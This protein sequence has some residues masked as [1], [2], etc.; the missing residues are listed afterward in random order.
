MHPIDFDTAQ[1]DFRAAG[2]R[3]DPLGEEIWRFYSPKPAPVQLLISVGIHGDETGP[4]EMLAQLLA[5][6]QREPQAQQV[7][8]LLCVGNLAAIKK[9][10]RYVDRDLNRLFV[11]GLRPDHSAYETARAAQ[12]MAAAGDFLASGKATAARQWHL[13]LHSTIRPSLFPRF[14]VVPRQTDAQRCDELAAW[15]SAA[16]VDAVVFNDL[17]ASTFSSYTAK[18]GAT[19]CTLELGRIGRFGSHDTS[20]LEN[21]RNAL[22]RLVRT[23]SLVDNSRAS[24]IA[25]FKV[26]TEIVKRTSQ[27][28]LSFATDVPNFTP[29]PRDHVVATDVD[30]TYRVGAPL[31]RIIF[32]NPKVDPGE[33]AGLL[34]APVE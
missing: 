6:W 4:I 20:V 34:I 28:K 2:F 13:D 5:E 19:S 30:V 10:H 14:A 11:E 18:L 25:T 31:E 1:A 32:P 15:L 8:L 33:R 27:F 17:P 16:D 23:G 3:V 26:T 7:D 12:L 9:S 24:A 29:F 21:F 22:D